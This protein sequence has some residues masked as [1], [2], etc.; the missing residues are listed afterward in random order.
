MMEDRLVT[1]RIFISRSKVMATTKQL[2]KGE[3]HCGTHKVSTNLLQGETEGQ[4]PCPAQ[5]RNSISGDRAACGAQQQHIWE[6]QGHS[7]QE[8]CELQSHLRW[9]EY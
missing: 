4:Q 6:T 8:W 2:K 9:G 7:A 5:Q 3:M 1:C